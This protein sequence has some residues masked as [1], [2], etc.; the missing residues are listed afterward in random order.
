MPKM[1][2]C[3]DGRYVPVPPGRWV[4]DP[5]NPINQGKKPAASESLSARRKPM[6]SVSQIDDR[7]IKRIA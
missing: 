7:D 6:A 4:D 3:A 5:N 1:L 2:K